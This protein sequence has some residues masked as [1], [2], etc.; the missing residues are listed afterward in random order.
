MFEN[1]GSFDGS[2]ERA[3][4]L[5]DRGFMGVVLA[6]SSALSRFVRIDAWAA[7]I[8]LMTLG[9]SPFSGG[10][11]VRRTGPKRAS[12]VGFA[13]LG[14]GYMVLTSSSWWIG[15]LIVLNWPPRCSLTAPI[16][17]SRPSGPWR[18]CRRSLVRDGPEMSM[19]G[20]KGSHQAG[21]PGL[22]VV[23]QETLLKDIL[24]YIKSRDDWPGRRRDPDLR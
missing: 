21:R 4:S 19:S 7:F 15:E 12:W 9:I 17:T 14:W 3:A 6:L 13:L 20:T 23:R 18:P 16:R 8:L 1:L 10:G 22:D 5:L 11:I 2:S 24:K